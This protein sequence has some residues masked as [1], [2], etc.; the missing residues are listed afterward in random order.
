MV[1]YCN[2]DHCFV[3]ILSFEFRVG[4]DDPTPPPPPW[5][6]SG[7]T[8][9]SPVL[10]IMMA[11][12][13]MESLIEGQSGCN[14]LIARGKV[15]GKNIRC[16]DCRIRAEWSL[17][18]VVEMASFAWGHTTPYS[19]HER[20]FPCPIRIHLQLPNLGR[21]Y[22]FWWGQ[23]DCFCGYNARMSSRVHTCNARGTWSTLNWDNARHKNSYNK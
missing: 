18:R 23:L 3:L 6:L 20:C 15:V 12:V 5:P 22:Y 4:I 7:F 8:D 1:A 13:A 16:F 17:D 14:R 10:F 2:S 9:W 19:N 11:C 21:N